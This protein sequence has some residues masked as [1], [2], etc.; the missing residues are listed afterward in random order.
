MVGCLS[1]VLKIKT[2]KFL[3]KNQLHKNILKHI[4][5]NWVWKSVSFLWEQEAG[6]LIRTCEHIHFIIIQVRACDA[7]KS[8]CAFSA[9]GQHS[10]HYIKTPLSAIYKMSGFK[11][12]QPIVLYIQNHIQGIKYLLANIIMLVFILQS[13]SCSPVGCRIVICLKEKTFQ[14]FSSKK[15]KGKKNMNTEQC[16]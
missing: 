7:H 15:K 13:L 16:Q 10:T 5:Y 6:L 14:S 8:M 9:L 2:L 1:P 4:Y 3:E 11:R 12:I